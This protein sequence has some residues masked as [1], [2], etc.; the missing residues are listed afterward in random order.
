MGRRFQRKIEDFTC[1]H[2]GSS[3]RG[4]GYTDHC[5]VCLFSKHVDINPGDRASS[6]GGL[7]EPIKAEPW[8]GGYRIYYKCLECG[9]LHRVKSSK[10]DSLEVI[11]S[12]VGLS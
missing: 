9:Y 7:M 11:F 2:C 1:E 5:P 4:D 6:C 10:E 3:T 8:H 12:L